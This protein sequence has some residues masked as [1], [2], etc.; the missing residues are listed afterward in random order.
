V[1]FDVY[2][3]TM[4]R[5]YRRDWENAGQR[6]TRAQGF[7][8]QMVHVGGEPNP[9][10]ADQIRHAVETWW[11]PLSSALQ[12]K[13]FGPVRWEEDDDQ[14]YFTE[15]PA[16]DGYTALLIWTAHAEHPDLP[17]PA[18]VPESWTD[19][20]AYQRSTAADFKSRFRTILQPQLWLPA[21]FPFV[22]SGP[23]LAVEKTCI[24]SVYTLKKQL[25]DLYQ[26]TAERLQELKLAVK[27]PPPEITKSGLLARLFS[28][29]PKSP[30]PATPALG[31]LAE[32]GISIFRELAT[33][34]CDHRL[35]MM[36]DY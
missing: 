9:P 26:E 31:E 21:E 28:R 30:E 29:K 16:W 12:T 4:T 5:Y 22:F 3:G 20:P 10:P 32:F 2:V 1:A 25:D 14:P 19:D 7:E 11:T 24:G 8:Y 15:R 36:L 17:L 27:T 34:A 23:T 33:K 6:L 13:G 18:H 35:P